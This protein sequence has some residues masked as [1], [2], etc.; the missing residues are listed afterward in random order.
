MKV[1]FATARA[2][3]PHCV[4]GAAL[5]VHTLLHLLV[6]HSHSCETVAGLSRGWRRKVMRGLQC[7]SLGQRY[8]LRDERNGYPCYR[9]SPRLIAALTRQ[10]LAVFKPDLLLTQL[11]G[12]R[13]ITAVALQSG[14]PTLLFVR[15]AE[16]AKWNWPA[17][18]SRLRLVSSSGYVASRLREKLGFESTVIHPFIRRADYQV[19]KRIGEFIT[20][21]NPIAEKGL[22]LALEIAALLP[23]RRFLFVESWPLGRLGRRELLRRLTAFPNVTFAPWTLD[24]KRTYS[25]TAVILMPSL[26]EEGFGRVM[27]EAQIN[28]IPVLGRATGAIPEVL[29]TSAALLAMDA[30]AGAWVDEIERLLSDESF[31]AARSAAGRANAARKAFDINSQLESFLAL[32]ADLGAY[33]G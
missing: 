7:L 27:L 28:G 12:A 9:T 6:E 17:C 16:F 32:A 13:E 3:L 15:D 18:H 2:Y 26:W 29:G 33:R 10:R 8:A 24:M 11:E 22:E 30:P 23:R 4:G 31:Y 20:L 19:E 25:R 1:L 5:S 21:I 14:V